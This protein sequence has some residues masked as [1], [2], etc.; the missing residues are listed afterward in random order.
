MAWRPGQLAGGGLD[1]FDRED[2]VVGRWSLLRTVGLNV[3][4]G[5]YGWVAPFTGPK[6]FW[7]VWDLGDRDGDGIPDGREVRLYGTDP[8]NPDS[9]GDGI[10][11]RVPGRRGG[12]DGTS[13]GQATWA[14]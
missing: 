14:Q 4:A 13:G 1:F 12:S 7:D 8:D 6:R 11:R 2:L 5:H 10:G 9:D 3:W